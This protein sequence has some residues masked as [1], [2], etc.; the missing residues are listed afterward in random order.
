M[1]R[2]QMQNNR[3]LWR[4]KY[5]SIYFILYFKNLFQVSSGGNQ[6]STGP[7]GHQWG[8]WSRWSACSSTCKGGK[9]N[10]TRK[11]NKKGQCTGSNKEVEDCNKNVN[12]KNNGYGNNSGYGNSNIWSMLSQR[13]D[14]EERELWRG[15]YANSQVNF[16]IIFKF[17]FLI[18]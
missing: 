12:C 3:W 6:Y 13:S 7:T 4:S 5:G 9:R 15:S 14:G 2:W 8:P 16:D 18:F 17:I 10:R 11:C 1:Q